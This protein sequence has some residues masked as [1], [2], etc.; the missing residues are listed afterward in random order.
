MKDIQPSPETDMNITEPDEQAMEAD[1]ESRDV[2]EEIDLELNRIGVT[3]GDA[4]DIVRAQ[5]MEDGELRLY[6][7]VREWI[8]PID[9]ARARL[10]DVAD[11]AGFDVFWAEFEE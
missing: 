1:I 11:D 8:G 9:E 7:D 3:W 10:A 2:T 4:V 6:N 5:A